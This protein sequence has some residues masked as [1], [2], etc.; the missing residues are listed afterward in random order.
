MINVV[1]VDQF[2]RDN[3]CK[4]PVTSSQLFVGKTYNPHPDGLLSEDIFGLEASPERNESYS[5][6]ELQ[7]PSINPMIYD[8]L[9]KRIERKIEDLLSGE[10]AFSFDENG[11]LVE[12]EEGPI[13]GMTALYENRDMWRFRRGDD[14]EGDRAQIVDMLEKH[15]KLG[16]FFMNKLIVVPPTFRPVTI[17]EEKNEVRP[18]ELNDLYIRIIILANQIKGVSGDLFDILAYKMQGMMKE[19]YEFIRSKISKKSGMIRNLMLGKRVDFSAR[20]VI[21]PD[22]EL[23]LGEVGIPIRMACQI[24]EPFL[25]YGMTESSY[26]KD[27]PEEFH[28]KVKEFLGKETV[29]D[30]SI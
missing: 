17:M 18:D 24:F 20:S 27:I 15:I 4:G 22:P 19:L 2:I 3:K 8:I 26:A 10:K 11:Y 25:L 16:T 5:W 1:S 30:V 13:Q 6:I 14:E 28:Q 21:A 7:C 23:R 9:Y 29:Y 12:D